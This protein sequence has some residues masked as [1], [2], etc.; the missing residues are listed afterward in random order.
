MP[1]RP[2]SGCACLACRDPLQQLQQ[3]F[4]ALGQIQGMLLQQLRRNPAALPVPNTLNTHT[5]FALMCVQ[6]SR[7]L[8]LLLKAELGCFFSASI[9]AFLLSL[10]S[11]KQ[12]QTSLHPKI[13][14]AAPHRSTTVTGKEEQAV[15]R[16]DQ[17]PGTPCR[18]LYVAMPRSHTL[19]THSPPSP[20]PH[21]ESQ[22]RAWERHTQTPDSPLVQPVAAHLQSA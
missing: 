4:N 10:W 2:A 14:P 18:S 5:Y 16:S 19:L 1:R 7:L 21:L 11:I 20:F 15:L 13:L 8:R 6:K 12:H 17:E 3:Q 22:P 9:L